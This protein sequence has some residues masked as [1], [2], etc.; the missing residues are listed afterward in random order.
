MNILRG[1][2]LAIIFLLASRLLEILLKKKLTLVETIRKNIP[3]LPPQFTV[4]K[5]RDITSTI[6][7]FQNDATIASYCPKQDCVVN[8][9]SAMHSFAEIASNSAE[10]KPKV[11]LYYYSTESGVDILDRMVRTYTC[12]RMTRRWPVALFYNMIDFT[13]VNAYVGWQQL[14]GGNTQIFSKKRGRKFFIRLG[15]E[16]AGMSSALLKQQRR[17]IQ[18]QSN[19]KK[20]CCNRKPGNKGKDRC[21]LCERSKDRKCRQACSACNNNICQEHLQVICMQCNH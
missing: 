14:H 19:R 21:Y 6:F 9:L 10:K 8:M 4:A 3:E 20:D 12:K 18:P 1:I 5:G 11:I 2:Y 17:A 16:L 15:K 7:G 13:I